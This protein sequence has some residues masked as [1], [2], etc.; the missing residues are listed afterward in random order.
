MAKHGRAR[1]APVDRPVALMWAMLTNAAEEL[2]ANPADALCKPTPAFTTAE[3]R[4]STT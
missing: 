1:S 2:M 4:S 3:I